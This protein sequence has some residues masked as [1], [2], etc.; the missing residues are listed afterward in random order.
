MVYWKSFVVSNVTVAGGELEFFIVDGHVSLTLY[1]NANALPVGSYYNA[2]YELDNGAVYVEQWIV[3]NV[4]TATLG[5]VRV[6]FP[7]SPSVIISPLQLSSL[8]AQAGMFLMWDGNKWV[9]GY[10][11]YFNINPNYI[12]MVAAA[13]GNDVNI[14]GSP[15]A[16]GGVLTLNIPDAGASAR[17][18][19]TTGTQT[20]AGAKTFTGAV[21]IGNLTVTGTVTLPP[22]SYVPVTRKIIAG[23]G[24]AITGNGDLTVD[25]TLSVVNDTTTQRVRASSAGTL[26][27][28]RQEINFISGANATVL[29]ADDSANNRVNVTVGSLALADPTIAKGD[30]LARSAAAINRLAVGTDGQV[31]TADSAQTLGVKWAAAAGQVASVFGRTGVVVAQAGDYVAAQVTNAVTVLG[32]YPD[33]PWITSLAWSKITGAPPSAVPSV[34]RRNG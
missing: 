4:A 20:F 19:V 22:N 29:V 11:S 24:L 28:S 16:L 13:S 27:S 18:V 31:L 15:V 32:S 21:S 9:P 6:S 12:S 10:P 14:T 2:K 25:R 7:P 23:T 34:F 1:S 8:N 17:G 33:P 30:M 26:V 3:P 5:Q